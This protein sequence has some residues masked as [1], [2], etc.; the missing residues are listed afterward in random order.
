MSNENIQNSN[1]DTDSEK[2]KTR[3]IVSIMM[4][5]FFAMIAISY[6]L[7]FN[8]FNKDNLID[9]MN[10]KT[11]MLFITSISSLIMII[12]MA[13]N[14]N[15]DNSKFSVILPLIC[16][17]IIIYLK[18]FLNI[19]VKD[20]TKNPIV[21]YIINVLFSKNFLFDEPF[22][23]YAYPFMIELFFIISYLT[24][25]NVLNSFIFGVVCAFLI[26]DFLI[27][28]RYYPLINIIFTNTDN[29]IY[30]YIFMIFY[31]ILLMS[32]LILSFMYF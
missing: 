32:V 12:I 17:N 19:S 11:P 24:S 7:F 15:D 9:S 14:N 10:F 30:R 29:L 26:F 3:Q 25:A 13:Y 28:E 6:V 5:I 1:L 31:F 23:T 4:I 27:E 18:I 16:L 8:S 2:W 20:I 21:A 22:I